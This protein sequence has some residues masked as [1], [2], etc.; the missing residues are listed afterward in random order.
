MVESSGGRQSPTREF[1]S[2]L[3][4]LKQ[5]GQGWL[6]RCPAHDDQHQSLSVNIGDDGRILI[7]CHAGC[8]TSNV[9]SALG[10]SFR[11]LF[12]ERSTAKAG[13]RKK[14]ERRIVATYDYRDPEGKLLFQTVRFEPKSF[15]QRRPDGQGGWH[16]NLQGVTP[17]LYRLPE[18]L[19]APADAVIYVVEGE[20]DV[21]TLVKMG[22][23]ATT[24]P[25]GAGK[26]RSEYAKFLKDRTVVIIPDDDPPGRKHAE[27]VAGIIRDVAKKVSVLT[28]PAGKDVSDWVQLHQGTADKLKDL[29][30]AHAKTWAPVQATPLKPE[31]AQAGLVLPE[32]VRHKLFDL[33]RELWIPG[34][35]SKTAAWIAALLGHYEFN[36][37][38]AGG[39]VQAMCALTQDE[40]AEFRLAE[41]PEAY[42]AGQRGDPGMPDFPGP[43]L[44]RAEKI[45]KL[46]QSIV[47]KRTRHIEAGEEK[48]NWSFGACT[49]FRSQP[50][51][52]EV[53]IEF[54][55]GTHAVVQLSSDHLTS[56]RRFTREV[57]DQ[58]NKLVTPVT[59]T[60]LHARV[61]AMIVTATRVTAPR[62]ATPVGALA[63]AFDEFLTQRKD[64][65]D[66]EA[67]QFW[68]GYDE[69]E[70][71]FRLSAL[72]K[73]L[74][75]SGLQATSPEICHYLNEN[76]WKAKLVRRGDRVFRMWA[77]AN[78]FN[79]QGQLSLGVTSEDNT[80]H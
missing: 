64:D 56:F 72:Q 23:H 5:S 65:T 34:Y 48:A 15:A 49:I 12:P 41:C 29:T 46:I 69:R 18:I 43:F 26:F 50:C 37:R 25:M 42:A 79:G 24:S 67:L 51:R 20:K 66:A 60:E 33:A 38:E 3:Q 17:V 35:R 36:Y 61:E 13:T 2:R 47:P 78:D 22:F 80:S 75:D 11:D 32:E 28:L 52:Y 9:V 59:V 7:K 74:K 30:N 10:L 31:H 77:R 76:G 4:G 53:R 57:L 55:D 58:A 63:I 54:D 40:E 8:D 14:P 19:A 6:A 1:F 70:T 39:L 73:W 71:F 45:R 62:E 27:Q 68:P 21:E 16:W 44:E